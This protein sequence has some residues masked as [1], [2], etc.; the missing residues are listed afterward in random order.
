MA[1]ERPQQ[2]EQVF[3]TITDTELLLVTFKGK[4]LERRL[5]LD[6][7]GIPLGVER[8]RITEASFIKGCTSSNE[9]LKRIEKFKLI[10][11]PDPSERW[12]Q[13][14]DSIQKRSLLFTHG[15]QVLLYSFPDDIEIRK[16][17]STE[18][19]VRKLVIRAEGN[20]VVVK[21]GNQKAFLEVAD[22]AW[23]SEYTLSRD[24]LASRLGSKHQ[25]TT[26]T[27]LPLI[28]FPI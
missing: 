14:F 26:L 19:A 9:I 16:M 7:I 10:N 12:I 22:G 21:K 2:K 24:V 17:F 1:E 20:N 15:E 27:G 5:F 18:P 13:F 25:E 11:D 8:Y 3:K 6:Q 28:A 23:V 4:S